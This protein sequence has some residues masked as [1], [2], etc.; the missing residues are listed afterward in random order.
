M[1]LVFVFWLIVSRF[2]S[3]G[4]VV[5]LV[6]EPFK[7]R[8]VVWFFVCVPLLVSGWFR[9]R[10]VFSFLLSL[11][12]ARETQTP[13]GGFGVPLVTLRPGHALRLQPVPP[14]PLIP[15]GFAP[16][17]VFFFFS[18]FALGCGRCLFSGWGRGS[19]LVFG[20]VSV[21]VGLCGFLA[22]LHLFLHRK[23]ALPGTRPQRRLPPFPPPIGLSGVTRL[24]LG[25]VPWTG[26][27]VAGWERRRL[28]DPTTS[29]MLTT[30]TIIVLPGHGWPPLQRTQAVSPVPVF[31]G[32]FLFFSCL[33]RNIRGRIHFLHL[34]C[35][36]RP[37]QPY[38]HAV[39]FPLSRRGKCCPFFPFCFFSWPARC[40]L[41]FFPFL[42]S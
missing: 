23:T 1:G 20:G 22:S 7:P 15:Q 9:R 3:L 28:C 13:F 16:E 8:P 39:L 19:G 12:G 5:C 35:N 34:S 41:S 42:F 32:V 2:L 6:F 11:S 36:I 17:H 4:L 30:M 38:C 29:R 37:R 25:V 33:Q 24:L 27:S 26:R 18:S 14:R 10:R 31:F 21:L 40:L